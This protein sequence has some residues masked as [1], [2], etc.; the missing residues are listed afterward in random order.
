M[1]EN[2][3][4]KRYF[5]ISVLAILLC[6]FVVGGKFAIMA[7]QDLEANNFV[8]IPVKNN[9]VASSQTLDPPTS[10]PTPPSESIGAPSPEPVA[11][12]NEGSVGLR[13]TDE[14]RATVSSEVVVVQYSDNVYG[15]TYELSI[16]FE[17]SSLDDKTIG[18]TGSTPVMELIFSRFDPQISLQKNINK[19]L[20]EALIFYEIETPP[21]VLAEIK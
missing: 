1:N 18:T 13:L 11:V 9:L 8:P 2:K 6:I 20:T 21:S 3:N 10:K 7:Y 14:G 19:Y 4:S 12:P 16:P 17:K 5:V 15:S